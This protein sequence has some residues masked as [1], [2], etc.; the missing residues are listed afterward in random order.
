MLKSHFDFFR[1]G[2]FVFAQQDCFTD[3]FQSARTY[4]LPAK[5]GT[6]YL[7]ILFKETTNSTPFDFTFNDS[8]FGS[9]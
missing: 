4:D 6:R 9:I 7:R 3:S 1:D 8:C 5:G 2:F